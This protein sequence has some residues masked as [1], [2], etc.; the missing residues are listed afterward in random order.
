VSGE[1]HI[2]VETVKRNAA[3]QGVE[4]SSIAI[5][6]DGLTEDEKDLMREQNLITQDNGSIVIARFT[7]AGEA[8]FQQKIKGFHSLAA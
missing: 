4:L 5:F 2:D 7:N 1:S 6:Y 3:E 8:L